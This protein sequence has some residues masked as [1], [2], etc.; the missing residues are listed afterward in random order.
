MHEIAQIY[1][2]FHLSFTINLFF[3]ME[4]HHKGDTYLKKDYH[5][6]SEHKKSE[7]KSVRLKTLKDSLGKNKTKKVKKIEQNK[8]HPII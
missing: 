6:L 4:D 8:G 5:K 3:S 7:E 2:S 1:I